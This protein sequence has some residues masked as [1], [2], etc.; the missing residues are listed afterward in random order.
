MNRQQMI[1]QISDHAAKAYRI[2]CGL[3]VGD[4]RITAEHE[5]RRLD[6]LEAWWLGHLDSTNGLT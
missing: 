5:Y 1:E 6:A 2:Y 4:D 3:P